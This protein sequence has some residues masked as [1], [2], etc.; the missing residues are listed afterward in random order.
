MRIRIRPL[1]KHGDPDPTSKEMRLRIQ[2]LT[3]NEDPD[4]TSNKKGGSGDTIENVVRD[5]KFKSF[6][7]FS[8]VLLGKKSFD[9]WYLYKMLMKKNR[10]FRR[11]ISVLSLL[12]MKSNALNKSNNRVCS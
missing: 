12:L 6:V 2:P 1:T 9:L 10:S 11:K 8:V 7:F 3:K 5:P 4:P